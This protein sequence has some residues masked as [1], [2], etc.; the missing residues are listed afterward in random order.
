MLAR[1]KSARSRLTASEVK[2]TKLDAPPCTLLQDFNATWMAESGLN[3]AGYFGVSHA[4]KMIV[5]AFRGSTNYRNW[6]ANLNT[7]T[8]C[9]LDQ[10][11]SKIFGLLIGEGKIERTL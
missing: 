10:A 6:V 1:L 11:A 9:H 7:L 2:F 5:V 3:V 4:Q 8:V